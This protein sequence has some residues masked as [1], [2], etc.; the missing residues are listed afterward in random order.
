M[1]HL[2]RLMALLLFAASLP[3]TDL[4]GAAPLRTR[5]VIP[6]WPGDGVGPGSENSPARLTITERSM[7]PFWPDRILTGITRPNLTAF[8][9]DRPNR[10]MQNPV[11][12]WWWCLS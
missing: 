10:L 7:L 2:P 4:A 5:D 12:D 9:P 8:V 6:L 1:P 11:N 3:L